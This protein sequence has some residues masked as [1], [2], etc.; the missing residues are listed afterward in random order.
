MVAGGIIQGYRAV[1]RNEAA[2]PWRRRYPPTYGSVAPVVTQP[3]GSFTPG[4]SRILPYNDSAVTTPRRRTV[5]QGQLL[6]VV[7]QRTE[8]GSSMEYRLLTRKS[9]AMCL[10]WYRPASPRNIVT[11]D[12]Y[13]LAQNDL[14]DIGDM[15]LSAPGPDLAG[16]RMLRDAVERY[17]IGLSDQR[18]EIG[19]RPVGGSW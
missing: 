7:V 17:R 5:G 3:P 1:F 8:K 14:A 6:P 9:L 15:P 11:T 16:A 12:R 13:Y 4:T 18:M 10:R 2:G 19:L